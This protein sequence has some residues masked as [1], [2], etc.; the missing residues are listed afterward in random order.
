MI[1]IIIYKYG[2]IQALNKHFNPHKNPGNVKSG[3]ASDINSS[4]PAVKSSTLY[5]KKR[6]AAGDDRDG[7]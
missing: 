3:S 2:C 7:S 6:K 1:K 5:R 4:L